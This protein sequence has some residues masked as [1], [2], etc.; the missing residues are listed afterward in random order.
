MGTFD[1]HPQE[2]ILQGDSEAA[3]IDILQHSSHVSPFAPVQITTNLN[4]YTAGDVWIEV[5]RQGGS[6]KW[7]AP[8]YPRIDFSVYAAKRSTAHDLAQVCLAVMFSNQNNY[9]GFGVR[10]IACEVET[11]LFEAQEKDT[12]QYKYIFSLRLVVKPA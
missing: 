6:Y 8:S 9:T 2:Y 11:D 1:N 10:F 4:G 5:T 3:C 12:N 7:H